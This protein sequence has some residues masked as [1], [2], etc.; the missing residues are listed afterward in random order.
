MF[1]TPVILGS[2]RRG[3][4]SSRVATFFVNELRRSGRFEP[5]LVD[6][7]EYAFPIME[8]RLSRRDDPPPRLEEFA[9]KIVRSDAL[10]IVT[11]EYNQGY[12]GVLKNAL[13]HLFAE[14]KRKPVGIVTVSSGDFGGL[15]C[16]FQL[17]H[18]LLHMGA[19]P[20]PARM[21]IQQVQKH[22]AEDGTPTDPA[23]TRRAEAFI[24]E[25]LWLTEAVSA[26]KARG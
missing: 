21:P 17:R 16:L 1:Y 18:I 24:A 10:L 26:R 14:Y 7:A 25:L 19:I 15:N 23:T 12:P 5:E 2:S 20:V 13:D 8:E 4:M 22:F 9:G 6:L 3:R 11:P